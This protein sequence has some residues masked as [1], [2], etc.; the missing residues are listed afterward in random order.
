MNVIDFLNSTGGFLGG[1]GTLF[2]G[3][4]ALWKIFK[5]ALKQTSKKKGG[6][7]KKKS[8]VRVL[9][10]LPGII[11]LAISAGIFGTRALTIEEQPSNV[12]LTSKAWDNFNKDK[13]EKAITYAEKCINEFRSAADRE[14]R[15]LENAHAPLPPKGKVSDQE[16]EKIWA[17]GLLNDVATCFYIKGRS[18]ENLGRIE[19]AKQ[20]YQVA[21]RYT[22]ARCWDP[23]GWFWS[24]AEAAL[25]RLHLLR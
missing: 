1:L 4:A 21:S 20:A 6:A 9:R 3:I 5:R 11:L 8:R 13:Y 12:Q 22:Y 23:K 25:D 10:L 7:M 19:E 18:A 15:E 2:L 17:R 14:Q 16:K 24:P